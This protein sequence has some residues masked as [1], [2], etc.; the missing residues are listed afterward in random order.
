MYGEQTTKQ[1]LN[2][3]LGID[4]S[5]LLDELIMLATRMFT[6]SSEKRTGNADF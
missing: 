6:I 5:L 3:D 2:Q 4:R 1:Y